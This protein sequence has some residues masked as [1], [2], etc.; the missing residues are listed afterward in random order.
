LA[1]DTV[2]YIVGKTLT[3]HQIANSVERHGPLVPI[4]VGICQR[5]DSA[6]L[7]Q[8][9]IFICISHYKKRGLTFKDIKAKILMLIDNSDAEERAKKQNNHELSYKIKIWKQVLGSKLTNN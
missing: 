3:R 2:W 5:T 1:K 9:F 8:E 6:L 7:F 4:L